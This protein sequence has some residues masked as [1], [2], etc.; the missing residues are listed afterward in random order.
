MSTLLRCLVYAFETLIGVGLVGLA[1][2]NG[3]AIYGAMQ[4]PPPHGCAPAI[5]GVVVLT[6]L[7]NAVVGGAVTLVSFMVG[8]I[9]CLDSADLTMGERDCA[10]RIATCGL[11]PALLYGGLA[12]YLFIFSG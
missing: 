1:L 12:A 7:F 2:G 4:L 9:V 10:Y 8:I 6:L 5:L 3:W 11:L